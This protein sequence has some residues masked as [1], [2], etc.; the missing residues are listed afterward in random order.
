M[1]H[2]LERFEIAQKNEYAAALCEL[3]AGA[4]RGHWMW[5]IFPQL[6]GLGQSETSRRY[7]ISDLLE[8]REYLQHPVLGPRL[9]EC[10]SVVL[11]LPTKVLSDIFLPPDDLKFGSC[12]TL[13]SLAEPESLVFQRAVRKFFNGSR[14][15]RTID[16]MKAEGT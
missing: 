14:D 10:S 11:N 4:K 8:A 7:G 13:F 9:I 5:F 2:P 16:L 6:V 15:V 1:T 12:M 3:K